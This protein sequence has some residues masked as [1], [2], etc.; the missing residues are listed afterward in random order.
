[1]TDLN[2]TIVQRRLDDLLDGYVPADAAAGMER[3]I[4]ACESCAEQRAAAKQL[5]AALARMPVPE[6]RPDFAAT[7]LAAA[8]QA[9][10]APHANIPDANIGARATASAR[11]GNNAAPQAAVRRRRRS[12]RSRFGVWLG[13]TIT[14]AAAAA[15]AAMLLGLPQPE[16]PAAAVADLRMTLYQPREIGL[17][18][19][20]ETAMPG[21]F[22]TVTVQGGIDLFGFD[23]QRELRWQTD[24]EAGMNMLSL[25]LI[26]HSLEQGRLTALVEHG[27][28]T[29]MMEFRVQIDESPAE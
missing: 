3:H 11:T 28:K 13:A 10:A 26:A 18:I 6:L 2:C 17:A 14:A 22:L 15:L 19:D 8:R 16:P 24:L 20:A 7:A 25:P 9:N 1:M 23:E 21:A 4:A 29:Q 12:S 5:R 27:D